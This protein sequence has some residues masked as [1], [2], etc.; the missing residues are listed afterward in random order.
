MFCY[1]KFSFFSGVENEALL[2]FQ[3][4]LMHFH[5]ADFEP[6]QALGLDS[7]VKKNDSKSNFYDF[8]V[9]NFN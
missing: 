1:E 8:F 2:R 5:A 3:A 7:I 6:L 9:R 4:Y